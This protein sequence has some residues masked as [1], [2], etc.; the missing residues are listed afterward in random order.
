MFVDM[1]KDNS[2]LV[3]TFSGTTSEKNT[4][5]FEFDLSE[6]AFDL[7]SGNVSSGSSPKN[8]LLLHKG[9]W[10]SIVF[11][12]V[13]IPLKQTFDTFASKTGPL[14]DKDGIIQPDALML[15]LSINNTAFPKPKSA[16]VIAAAQPDMN[17]FKDFFFMK[18]NHII[19]GTKNQ[20]AL[21]FQTVKV[22]GEKI[23]SKPDSGSGSDSE[24]ESK[25]LGFFKGV[26]QKF[27]AHQ[28]GKQEAAD[29]AT[30]KQDFST[31]T[32]SIVE[33]F[34]Q[35]CIDKTSGKVDAEKS[36]QYIR[37]LYNSNID[38]DQLKNIFGLTG[39]M[40]RLIFALTQPLIPGDNNV[41]NSMLLIVRA[42]AGDDSI[43]SW[44]ERSSTEPI[45]VP[46]QGGGAGEITDEN[47]EKATKIIKDMMKILTEKQFITPNV[48]S[49]FTNGLETADQK[50]KLNKAY[51]DSI[52]ISVPVPPP[53]AAS[54]A[55]SSPVHAPA[56]PLASANVTGMF[57][58]LFGSNSS[59]NSASSSTASSAGTNIETCGNTANV[60]CNGENLIVTVT[61]KTSDLLNQC[62][63]THENILNMANQ[64][65]NIHARSI[66]TLPPPPPQ[67]DYGQ[68]IIDMANSL[69]YDEGKTF[70]NRLTPDH[71]PHITDTHIQ[72]LK[73]ELQPIFREAMAKASANPSG[74]G[75]GHGAGVV[76][77][78]GP[79]V[80]DGV[81]AKS[82][83]NLSVSSITNLEVGK[84]QQ[85]TISDGNGNQ[86]NF[87]SL[88]PRFATVDDKGIVTGVA[89][90]KAQI[91]IT[92]AEND[93]MKGTY[94][95]I[96][97]IVEAVSSA[98]SPAKPTLALKANTLSF[99]TVPSDPI[100]LD[101]VKSSVINTYNLGTTN[102]PI[103]KDGSTGVF[104]YTSSDTA[105]ATV[106]AISGVVT[107][108]AVGK[109]VIN[110]TQAA[111]AEYAE[112]KL[113]ANI[114]VIDSLSK[115]PL[116]ARTSEEIQYD[117]LK[118]RY[119]ASDKTWANLQ[120]KIA[121][122]TS[123][124]KSITMSP[125]E[126][127]NEQKYYELKNR[128]IENNDRLIKVIQ[129]RDIILKEIE[130]IINPNEDVV[131]EVSGTLV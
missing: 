2:E 114:K 47:I 22:T 103:S 55:V 87:E 48:S 41:E 116:P 27:Q 42:L 19:F 79:G 128:Y 80:G 20:S 4:L 126:Q 16:G 94:F 34:R 129:K 37:N 123:K 96:D 26:A 99:T 24:S 93:I 105:V 13:H 54:G 71:F 64:P 62:G 112:G 32:N 130:S 95:V 75:D 67:K 60:T 30:R 50:I 23:E 111:T 113:T 107:V 66:L 10:I 3:S 68:T 101:I 115:T 14:T 106:D 28:Q 58:K 119:E 36:N 74:A 65:Q 5:K 109:C 7:K 72:A 118:A 49:T 104:T 40:P 110:I 21:T 121:E 82:D 18:T 73:H 91:K 85:L 11:K 44:S 51:P 63:I 131:E 57:S 61:L 17:P 38:A 108:V 77:K 1:S 84:T 52:E 29:L 45:L 125:E 97:V 127:A 25:K 98:P 35:T 9:S 78:D 102:V 100:E 53:P 88:T 90:G 76:N 122:I 59:S 70:I 39:Q 31:K 69:P 15:M 81:N 46:V 83:N 56:S 86:L 8:I 124:I 43:K 33:G 92:Q 6:F 120:A 12:N 117:T 89:V